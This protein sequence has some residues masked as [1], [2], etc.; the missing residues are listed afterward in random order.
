MTETERTKS[1]E[2][3]LHFRLSRLAGDV[4]WQMLLHSLPV[5]VYMTDA[6][7]TI[8][9]Y[10]ES[11]AALWGVRPTLGDS[12]FCGSWKL[13]W[14]DGAPLP[15]DECPMALA[16]RERRPVVGMEAIAERPDGTR[17]NFTPFPA[18]I[19]GPN[20]EL[21]GA[22]NLLIDVTE[23]R[24]AE[25]A[26]RTLAAV[27]ESS[28]DAIITLD[29][30]GRITSWNDGATDLFG[31][32]P[33]EIVG[34]G[35]NRLIP[36]DRR[37]E[38]TSIRNRI[39]A[40][41]RIRRYETVRVRRDQSTVPVELS[42]SAIRDASG[43]VVGIAKFAHDVSERRASEVRRQLLLREMSHRVK[44]VFALSGAILALSA[45]GNSD[46]DSFV[47][48]VQ[49][50]L[51][52]LA[53]AHELTLPD[54]K[55]GEVATSTTLHSLLRAITSPFEQVA[56]GRLL[57]EGPDT[58]VSGQAATS[59]AL[60]FHEIA[61]NAA[62]YGAFSSDAGKVWV[63]SSI[64]G[65]RIEIQWLEHGGPPV[66]APEVDGFGTEMSDSTIRGLLQGELERDWR[67]EGLRI[68]IYLPLTA[69]G[70]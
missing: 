58:A 67:P 46:P 3:V 27:V 34:Q 19:F 8:T 1:P 63:Q 68:R 57:I 21:T 70:R 35:I 32:T 7:G 66:R 44:N 18:P 22:V 45:K 55:R 5:A 10:N 64:T 20:G 62:K 48:Q 40:G 11:A 43:G 26:A 23:R 54:L 14:P 61:T 49:N 60:V 13:Y 50:R 39:I 47:S 53:R 56:D 12:S 17:V 59:L 41:E 30:R 52:A 37:I 31:Y 4:Q 2:P 28:V 29:L 65:D 16:L 36:P 33:D 69:L 15:H 9:F 25:D 24:M 38:E 6:R 51:V 42:V